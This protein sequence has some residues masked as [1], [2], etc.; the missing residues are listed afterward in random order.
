[1]QQDPE[2]AVAGLAARLVHTVL[3]Q[4][5]VVARRGLLDEQA[6]PVSEVV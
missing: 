2:G 1:L 6:P 3:E 4:D 5:S